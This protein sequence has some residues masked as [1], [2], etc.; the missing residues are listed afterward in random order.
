MNMHLYIGIADG[1][2]ARDDTYGEVYPPSRSVPESLIEYILHAGE[3][4]GGIRLHG[5]D[6]CPSPSLGLGLAA[7]AGLLWG[8]AAAGH[9]GSRQRQRWCRRGAEERQRL[10]VRDVGTGRRSR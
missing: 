5:D 8:G 3:Q 1:S 4:D 7:G 10:G 2:M 9:P 6:G